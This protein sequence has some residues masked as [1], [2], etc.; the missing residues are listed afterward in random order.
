MKKRVT[1]LLLILTFSVL[2]LAAFA[3]EIDSPVP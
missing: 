3:G 1:S 2:P